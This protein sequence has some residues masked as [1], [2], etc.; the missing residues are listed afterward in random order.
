MLPFSDIIAAIRWWAVLLVL[1][2]AVL[3][4]TYTLFHK[5]ADRGYAFTKMVG[6]LLVSY[7]FWLLG[8]L[9]LLGNNLGGVLVSL[10][11]V[12]AVSWRVYSLQRNKDTKE[13]SMSEWLRAN[14]GQVILTELLFLVMFALWVWVRAQNPAILNTEKPMEFAFL[15]ALGRSPAM[16]P[17]DPW[18]SGFAISYY[19]FG[20][21]MT[22]VVARLA[23]VPEYIAFNLAIAWLVAGT[24]VGAFGLVYNLVMGINRRGAENVV[25]EPLSPAPLPPGSPARRLSL[26]LG[27]IAAVAL[28]LA[29]NQQMTLELLYANRI[30]SDP[31]WQWLD[32]RDLEQLPPLPAPDPANPGAPLPEPTPR[33]E[34]GSWWW[35]RSS[36]VINEYHLSGRP[37]EGLEPIVEF[38]GFSFG[39]GDMHPH[40]LALPFAFL[41]LAVAYLWF[42]QSGDWRL[43]IRDWRSAISNLQPLISNPLWLFTVLMLGGLSFL[44]TW[45]VLIHLFVVL[46]AF[47]LARRRVEGWHAGLLAQALA[48]GG[49][50][51]LWAVLAYLPFYLGFKSQAGAPY[52]LPMLMRPTRLAQFLVIFAMPLSSITLLLLAVAVRRRFQGWRVGLL[53]AVSLL[54]ALFLLMGFFGWLVASSA[55]GAGRVIG[56]ATELGI[57]LAPRPETAV[58][59]GWGLQAIFALLPAIFAARIAY[60]AL[61]LFLLA[62]I[63]LVVTIWQ[64]EQGSGNLWLQG[65]REWQPLGGGDDPAPLLPSPPA[66][67]PF[68]LLLILTGALLTLGPEFLY[69]RDNFG[70]RL[71]TTF[72]FYYQAWV[73]W[74]V[75]ALFA[76]GYL[77]LQFRQGAQRIVPLLATA[78]FLP[79]F[80]VA[81][82]FPFYMAQSRAIEYRGPLT[83]ENRQ[84][85]SLNGLSYLQPFS[86][87]EYEA[88]MWLRQN[89]TGTPVI[90]EAVGGQ[91]SDYGR[92]SASTGL[93]TLLGWAGHEYQ[94]R[95]STPEPAER[96]PAVRQIYSSASWDEIETLLNRY[97]VDYIYVGS[98]EMATYGA[99]VREKFAG[100]L[101][102]AFQSGDVTIYKWQGE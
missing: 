91:Y 70:M 77:W 46:G 8:S 69:L 62:I 40:V 102:V 1:G 17:L 18:L 31:L 36:R 65:A 21:V 10:G 47:V 23:V 5:L 39:L 88:I 95:G 52:L 15:N 3:P 53:T 24:A 93:P 96:D 86:P 71:N 9:G 83:A 19:Y 44:N 14:R 29:G 82:L 49:L 61:T 80:A 26:I 59:L 25:E 90:V 99:Q 45:D 101:E 57:D 43:G 42:L 28:P 78:V 67:L 94:W 84:P 68:V 33:F 76:L 12:T 63:A 37:E 38:P 13:Q 64:K 34:T 20:Y 4:F 74:G 54:V 75:A 32:V 2:T 6:V 81:L 72:K 100:L 58:A 41:S 60:P 16:P 51:V 7:L 50:L 87:S 27:L 66:P 98:R 35:W 48:M 56:L 22:A 55:D 11:L 89:I 73:L 79:L 85:A 97:E 30:G 92:I